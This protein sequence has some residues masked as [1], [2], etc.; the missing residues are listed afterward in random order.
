MV[1]HPKVPLFLTGNKGCAMIWTFDSLNCLGELETPTKE[2]IV[3]TLKFN[4]I[5]DKLG[6]VD[7][8]GNFYLWKFNKQ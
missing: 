7:I 1:S 6:G 3:S 5:G 2:S 8:A 4:N